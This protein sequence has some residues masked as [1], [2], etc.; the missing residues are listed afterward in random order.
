[1]FYFLYYKNIHYIT[2]K[3]CLDV[4]SFNFVCFQLGDTQSGTKLFAQA[5]RLSDGQE[6]SQTFMNM[7]V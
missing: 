6:K 5:E 2:R 3:V 7:W 1:M 4:Y